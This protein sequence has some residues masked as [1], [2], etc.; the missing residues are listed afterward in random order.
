MYSCVLVCYSYVTCM[1]L[2]CTRVCT[3]MLL[4]CS[5]VYS[6][7]TRMYSYVTRMLL[8]CSFSHNPGHE[9]KPSG[10]RE[11]FF[12]NLKAS[13][14]TVCSKHLECSVAI[15]IPLQGVLFV[16]TAESY[17]EISG[18]LQIVRKF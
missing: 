2:V 3:R 8:V 14:Y 10:K 11:C 6:Y 9:G 15:Y 12:Y 7:V 4:V 1:L 16:E 17:K 13:F 18:I 5:R